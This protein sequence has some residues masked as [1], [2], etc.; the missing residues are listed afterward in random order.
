MPIRIEHQPSSASVG[1]A[2]YA[3]GRNSARLR[4]QK[5]QMDLYQNQQAI[6]SRREGQFMDFK[7]QQ[8]LN[9]DRRTDIEARDTRLRALELGD[10]DNRRREHLAD[11][12]STRAFAVRQSAAAVESERE[13][14][15][16]RR[17]ATGEEELTPLAQKKVDALN[18]D[19]VKESGGFDDAQKEELRIKTEEDI[20]RIRVAPGATRRPAALDAYNKNAVYID[21]VTGL[22]ERP[23]RGKPA[24][25]ILNPNGGPAIPTHEAQQKAEL[26]KIAATTAAKQPEKEAAAR[27]ADVKEWDRQR[28]TAITQ[29]MGD[30]S[31]SSDPVSFAEAVKLA[32]EEVTRRLGPRPTGAAPAAGGAAPAATPPGWHPPMAMPPGAA[33]PGAA[34]A[35]VAAGGA[36]GPRRIAAGPDGMPVLSG[37]PQAQ[38]PSTSA[39]PVAP[40]SPSQQTWGEPAPPAPT[41]QA[42]WPAPIPVAP[43][44]AA[45]LPLAIPS[46]PEI[47]SAYAAPAGI[48]SEAASNV[49]GNIGSGIAGAAQSWG[50]AEQARQQQQTQ[51]R[52]EAAAKRQAELEERRK[53]SR[54][55]QMG[56]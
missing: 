53:R 29:I 33:A 28:N 30:K 38:A 40:Y 52:A 5:Y 26:D 35:P 11:L 10:A 49:L 51:Q 19:Y 21:P 7:Y 2:A 3:T 48:L 24:N 22:A 32:E 12:E 37:G 31:G 47:S 50:S 55:R 17:V 54:K 9:T 6:Q 13:L 39:A 45:P 56:R 34:A 1:M 16:E 27:K 23:S 42:G 18:D 41:S 4:Q 15:Q 46:Q 20:R 36:A 43:R 44:P 14:A 8:Q 25:G